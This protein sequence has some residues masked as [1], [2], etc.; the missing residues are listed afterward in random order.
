MEGPYAT[1][2][3]WIILAY[4]LSGGLLVKFSLSTEGMPLFNALVPGEHEIQDSEIWPRKT[5]GSLVWRTDGQT[6]P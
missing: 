3:V 6:A 2:Y 1:I 4:I 5:I